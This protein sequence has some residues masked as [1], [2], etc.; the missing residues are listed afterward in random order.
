MTLDQFLEK[1]DCA[2]TDGSCIFRPSTRV[3]MVTNGGCKCCGD[4]SKKMEILRLIIWLKTEH[5]V[6]HQYMIE[7]MWKISYDYLH[8]TTEG[9]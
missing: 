3:G 8:E 5:K 7:N 9:G 1:L 2:C 6:L 4:Y